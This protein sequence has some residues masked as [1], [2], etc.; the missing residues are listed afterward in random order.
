LSG[1]DDVELINGEE[2]GAHDERDPAGGSQV[3]AV[4]DDPNR[5]P[6]RGPCLDGLAVRLV[7]REGAHSSIVTEPAV[8]SL[9]MCIHTEHCHPE[10]KQRAEADE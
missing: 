2:H 4:A 3:G 6:P 7:L 8:T 5:I 10:E 9:L 1:D